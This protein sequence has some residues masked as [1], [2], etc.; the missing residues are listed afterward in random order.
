[1][2]WQW[3]WFFLTFP[4]H[5][6]QTLHKQ[7]NPVMKRIQYL[8]A[9]NRSLQEGFELHTKNLECM[10]E[11]LST[12]N[13]IAKNN[14]TRI[15]LLNEDQQSTNRRQQEISK[16]RNLLKPPK[17][18]SKV[19]GDEVELGTLNEHQYNRSYITPCMCRGKNTADRV[20]SSTQA[21]AG[22]DVVIESSQR[23]TMAKKPSVEQ[24]NNQDL[25]T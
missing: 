14:N 3:Y 24:P 4:K 21:E 10:L 9:S 11:K 16:K 12:I 6:D 20:S 18:N 13:D 7:L 22:E 5:I 8:G 25:D 2:E 1:M 17:T 19:P 23:T 15:D